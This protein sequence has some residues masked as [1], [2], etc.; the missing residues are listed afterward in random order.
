MFDEM[1][2]QQI[3]RI[4]VVAHPF[5]LHILCICKNGM[6]ANADGEYSV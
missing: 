3:P 4:H 6:L 5:S 2:S 1:C